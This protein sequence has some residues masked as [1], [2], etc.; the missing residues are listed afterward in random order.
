M[1]K[2]NEDIKQFNLRNENISYILKIGANVQPLQLHYRQK[3]QNKNYDYLLQQQAR[4]L[5]SYVFENNMSCSL[6]HTCN[7]YP[8]FGTTDFRMPAYSILQNNGS[9][10]TD[11]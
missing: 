7:E 8:S 2:I 10:I 6:E 5:S 1:I 9:K 4:P 11:L 3:I